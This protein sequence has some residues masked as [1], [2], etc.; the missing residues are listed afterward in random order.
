[1]PIVF[2]VFVGC[3][4]NACTITKA[5]TDE[6]K[7]Y[8]VISEYE[9][10]QKI[11]IAY[12]KSCLSKQKDMRNGCDVYVENIKEYN[13]KADLLIQSIKIGNNGIEYEKTIAEALKII[14]TKLGYY[15]INE[16]GLK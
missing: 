7:L 6:Q 8:S 11:A 16:G 14:T 5:E 4:T 1:M 13:A 3:T 2:L 9:Q 15:L 10:L 12:K